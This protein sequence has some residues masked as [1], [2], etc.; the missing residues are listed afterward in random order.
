MLFTVDLDDYKNS[1]GKNDK[2]T[3]LSVVF[4]KEVL[5]DEWSVCMTQTINRKKNHT[6]GIKNGQFKVAK[7]PMAVPKESPSFVGINTFFLN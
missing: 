6:N 3:P 2:S 5:N 4:D 1:C 7:Y